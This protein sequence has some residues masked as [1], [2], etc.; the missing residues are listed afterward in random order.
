MKHLLTLS[1]LIVMLFAG[2]SYK[3]SAIF[4]ANCSTVA[5]Q[6]PQ[7]GYDTLSSGANILTQINT[8]LVQN[9][10]LILDP[11]QNAMIAMSLL[12]Q[13]KN[14]L[15]L[16]MGSLGG[17]QPLFQSNPDQWIK[18]QGLNAVRVNLSDI[19]GANGLFSG[20]L[21]TSLTNSYRNSSNLSTQLKS[22]SVSSI[23]NLVQNNVCR[24]AN[25]TAIAKNDT[26]ASTGS[27][28]PNAVNI[29][30]NQL[31]ASL[32]SGNPQTDLNLARRLSQV[33]TQRPDVVGDKALYAV[34]AGDNDYARTVQASIL[35]D[36]DKEEKEEAAKDDLKE[37]GGIVS[38]S[39][40]KETVEV[41]T[42]FDIG[43]IANAPC[44][45]KELTNSS[46]A[47]SSQ[48]QQALNSKIQK[49]ISS[50][51]W[52]ILGTL[53]SLLSAGL[54]LKQLTSSVAGAVG[55]AGGGNG[56]T[57]TSQT[58]GSATTPTP[59]LTPAA[60]ETLVSTITT[61]LNSYTGNLD[62]LQTADNN[63][64]SQITLA[65]SY[66][67]QMKGCYQG[68]V[69]DFNLEQSDSRVAPAFSYYQT[70]AL[71]YAGHR[72]K[73][74]HDQ[75][76]MT[77]ARAA[78]SALK[79]TLTSSNSSEEINTAYEQFDEKI[80]SGTIVSETAYVTRDAD[81]QK[82]KAENQLSTIEGG[83]L[84]NLNTQCASLRQQLTPFQGF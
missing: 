14:T 71:E 23:P 38:P 80:T 60:K 51:G 3:A 67:N 31:W 73:I 70:K 69:N 2:S 8:F 55:G 50:E 65:E 33:Q 25:L 17:S 16:V 61:R 21:L 49:T 81:Y 48:L 68:I 12:S 54:E 5:L 46:A 9:K 42:D 66:L 52:G 59:N 45:V 83:E 6:I 7:L 77:A 56:G 53:G 62:K 15:N 22:L 29:R 76:D 36:K 47:V 27:A 37:G 72:A 43:T 39:N 63:L 75:S 24:D 57:N 13:Q 35:V 30:K 79:N 78:V 82:L 11:L 84:Y 74:A 34:L 26:M 44:R 64:S 1:L 40:C 41:A 58:T 10:T 28:D 20:S 18:N 32:C 4:C 19:S